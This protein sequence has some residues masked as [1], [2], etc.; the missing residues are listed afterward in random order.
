MRRQSFWRLVTLFI[1]AL[2]QTSFAS[3]FA[4]PSSGNSI[5]GEVTYISSNYGDTAAYIAQHYNLGQNVII[6]ANPGVSENVALAGGRFLKIPTRFILPPM[7]R[8]GIV[9][10]LPEMRLYYYP[11]GTNEVMTFPIGIGRIGKTIPIRP[12]TISRKKINPTWTPPEDIREFNRQQGIELPK[13]M[14]A[15]PDNPLGPYGIYLSIPTYLIHSTI[16]PES[17]GRRASFGCIRMNEADIKQFFPIVE[18]GTP[19][20][21]VDMPAKVGWDGDHLYLE[22]HPPLEERASSINLSEVV[23]SIMASTPHGQVTLI[24]WQ[25]V[26]YL[27]GMPDGVPHEIGFKAN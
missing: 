21:I 7:A 19:V 13:T 16:F 2:S 27:A 11:P 17:I 24:N 14:A 25:L 5:I 22:A 4:L 10:N 23:D 9:I 20:T 3:E 18:P 1:A 6:S 12:A 26:S 8:K 15:G